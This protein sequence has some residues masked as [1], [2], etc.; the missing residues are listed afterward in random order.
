MINCI[1]HNKTK[2]IDYLILLKLIFNKYN[3][4]MHNEFYNELIDYIKPIFIFNTTILNENKY[5][6]RYTNTLSIND[7]EKAYNI[8]HNLL[9]IFL[10]Y[11]YTYINFNDI[12]INIELY[13]YTNNTY[14][15][16]NSMTSLCLKI[17]FIKTYIY[18][19]NYTISSL[20]YEI[21]LD[22]I[23]I[24]KNMNNIN[25]F[26]EYICDIWQ[27][28]CG[29]MMYDYIISNS[30]KKLL[31]YDFFKKIICRIVID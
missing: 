27:N 15:N 30:I 11:K 4:Y 17:N 28:S 26:N 5:F 8:K 22:E 18:M 21:P 20:S 1:H 7:F 6:Y 3:I 9:K 14:K 25:K 12:F 31:Y 10:K 24:L 16:T 23:N 13:Y 29:I 19:I 2:I